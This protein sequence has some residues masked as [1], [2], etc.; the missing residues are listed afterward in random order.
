[1]EVD[2][3]VQAQNWSGLKLLDKLVDDLQ[4][5]KNEAYAI[6]MYFCRNGDDCEC[7]GINSTCSACRG[8]NELDELFIQMEDESYDR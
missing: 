8:R 3:L 4:A 2:A 5:R 7:N 1:M 6:F